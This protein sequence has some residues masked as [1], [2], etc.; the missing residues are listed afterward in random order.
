MKTSTITQVSKYVNGAITLFLSVSLSTAQA[1]T[2]TGENR[3]KEDPTVLPALIYPTNQ[4]HTI[5]VNAHNQQRGPLTI[6]IRDANGQVK[7]TE[8]SF[9]SKYIG[10]FNLAPLGEGIYT[11]E[12]SN[13]AGQSFSRAFRLETATPRIIALGDPQQNPF[14]PKETLGSL[15][16]R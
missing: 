12:L 8:L 15:I 16:R 6:V 9:A 7:H 10:R 13:Q 2:F 5:R 3:L 14:E 1:Q 4:A 11:F